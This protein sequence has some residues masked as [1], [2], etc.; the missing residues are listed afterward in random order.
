MTLQISTGAL[1]SWDWKLD[2][3]VVLLSQVESGWAEI[4]RGI[5]CY[6]NEERCEIWKGID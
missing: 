5:M 1:E 3:Y 2:F 6:D 4:H